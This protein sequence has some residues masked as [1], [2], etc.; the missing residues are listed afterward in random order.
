MEYFLWTHLE[1]PEKNEEW[2]KRTLFVITLIPIFATLVV[3]DVSLRKKLF[4]LAAIYFLAVWIMKRDE[5][6][7][8]T[9]VGEK[10][11]HLT[12]DFIPPTM[13]YILGWF[14][15]FFGSILFFNRDPLMKAYAVASALFSLAIVSEGKTYNSYWCFTAVGI[16][17]IVLAR[18]ISNKKGSFL[19]Q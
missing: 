1:D 12:Y 18:L 10:D 17:F 4:V 3:D 11:G 8:R 15:F 5:I 19:F 13:F 2:S 9:G 14:G 6:T 7:Y 16:W